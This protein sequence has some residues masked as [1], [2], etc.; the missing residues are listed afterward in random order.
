MHDWVKAVIFL[1]F[2]T[3]LGALEMGN[4]FVL[5][6]SHLGTHSAWQ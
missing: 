2:V 4:D 6:Q 3:F 5:M 1:M